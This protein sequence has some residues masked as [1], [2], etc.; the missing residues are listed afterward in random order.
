MRVGLATG[1]YVPV[2]TVSAGTYTSMVMYWARTAHDL[3]RSWHGEV[4]RAAPLR[5]WRL[6][7]PLRFP[8]V[9][10]FVCARGR[11]CVS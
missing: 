9:G 11:I 7:V 4:L 10:W 8:D 6:A 1:V 5:S 2:P 3:M